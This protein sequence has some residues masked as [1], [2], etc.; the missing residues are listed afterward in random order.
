ME[1]SRNN[2][3]T[4][5][6]YLND[7]GTSEKLYS[8]ISYYEISDIFFGFQLKYP[9]LAK[10]TFDALFSKTNP[11]ISLIVSIIHFKGYFGVQKNSYYG[12]Y[13]LYKSAFL[14][15]NSLA[16][17]YL[18][19]IS[20]FQDFDD[21]EELE[22]FY[23]NSKYK[24]N[25]NLSLNSDVKEENEC[26]IRNENI[27]SNNN[28]T[29]F[30]VYN[31]LMNDMENP[32]L[33]KSD[34]IINFVENLKYDIDYKS[35]EF[36]KLD[37]MIS[38]FYPNSNEDLEIFYLLCSF[39]FLP[40][41][42]IYSSDGYD[43]NV[44]GIPVVFNF[45]YFLDFLDNNLS[46]IN[47]LLN[48]LIDFK[49]LN[50]KQLVKNIEIDGNVLKDFS[51]YEFFD[52]LPFNEFDYFYI[53][54]ILN[55]HFYLSDNSSIVVTDEK[56]KFETIF[57]KDLKDQ[58]TKDLY[59]KML[60]LSKFK[61]TLSYANLGF[62]NQH[63]YYFFLPSFVNNQINENFD[64]SLNYYE[65]TKLDYNSYSKIIS[66]EVNIYFN[67][68]QYSKVD[69]LIEYAI[70]MR[71]DAGYLLKYNIILYYID[72]ELR[73]EMLNKLK[74]ILLKLII[75]SIVTN[76]VYSPFEYFVY[77]HIL[78]KY[79]EIKIPEDLDF[80]NELKELLELNYINSN[81]IDDSL[82]NTFNWVTDYKSEDDKAEL[83]FCSGYILYKES[84]E[85]LKFYFLLKNYIDKTLQYLSNISD[86]IKDEFIKSENIKLRKG[87]IK[88]DK[89]MNLFDSPEITNKRSANK[90][91]SE[92]SIEKPKLF[93]KI[94]DFDN[95]L[96]MKNKMCK[97]NL[98]DKEYI[99]NNDFNN[100]LT[101]N[102]LNKEKYFDFKSEINDLKSIKEEINII[103]SNLKILIKKDNEDVDEN[104]HKYC[105]I[106][107]YKKIK[108]LQSKLL[109]LKNDEISTNKLIFKNENKS[110]KSN[111]SSSFIENNK[112]D[113]S[114]LE[115][116]DNE[117]EEDYSNINNNDFENDNEN[118][119]ND[120]M[121]QYNAYPIISESHSP[122]SSNTSLSINNYNL[123]ND[124]N[125]LS[126]SKAKLKSSLSIAKSKTNEYKSSGNI[127]YVYSQKASTFLNINSQNSDKNL[128]YKRNLIN[129]FTDL[130]DDFY[131]KI[132]LFE[133]I[134]SINRKISNLQKEL[135]KLKKDIIKDYNSCLQRFNKT[136]TIAKHYNYKRFV[137]VLIYKTYYKMNLIKSSKSCRI[138]M[139]KSSKDLF[140][141][142]NKS[143]TSYPLEY[144]SG[145]FFYQLGEIYIKEIGVLKNE[146]LGLKYYQLGSA[147][148][149]NTISLL[150][151]L[152]TFRKLKLRF[153]ISNSEY[154]QSLK[155]KKKGEDVNFIKNE[156]ETFNSDEYQ[157]QI[158]KYLRKF[159]LQKESNIENFSID[160]IEQKYLI[161]LENDIT[162]NDKNSFDPCD[163]CFTNK[164][165]V[166][167][168]PCNHYSCCINCTYKIIMTQKCPICRSAISLFF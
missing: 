55:Y 109:F 20:F 38:K 58:K 150:S 7:K 79:F 153:K 1:Y 95:D 36:K 44:K 137:A 87:S 19:Q 48:L 104:S 6:N 5:F 161:D 143:V 72:K 71:I 166:L 134:N 164:K 62:I 65:L 125:L 168:Y 132:M 14:E 144:L 66:E 114:D 113:I 126:G 76:S 68:K 12:L 10:I 60:I 74:F 30:T 41:N 130:N 73:Y 112:S 21:L 140:N 84:S 92:F 136:N 93:T 108:Y 96:K 53:K 47:N 120:F 86:S 70:K 89:K 100:N 49:S 50:I 13:Y 77:Y 64:V 91:S 80:Y 98:E 63:K 22:K 67:L 24:I 167:F 40:P 8:K 97:D 111:D 160:K 2:K 152:N 52:V 16:F 121:N 88:I 3:K 107:D 31:Q 75:Q 119:Q 149:I 82:N 115:V 28:L 151:L 26:I 46:K 34:F 155:F 27:Q 15:K 127:A 11:N 35:E 156:I 59:L 69:E 42:N 61:Y 85:K 45:A 129:E 25:T 165:S 57:F 145:S 162:L 154:Y 56:F 135:S 81:N 54:S 118:S 138:N 43:K 90:L 117:I 51:S 131:I 124:L 122:I 83:Y 105:S 99:I 33:V 106:Y 142:F 103:N 147:E 78:E 29:D 32:L 116:D 128:E 148:N 163:I 123:S 110:D 133:E 141:L 146:E 158:K 102:C 139:V 9:K 157:I 37:L 17:Y 39:S 94:S 23:F 4:I 18:F 159:S 101:K